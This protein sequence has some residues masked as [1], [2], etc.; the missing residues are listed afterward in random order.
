MF[1]IAI[2]QNKFSRNPCM[3]WKNSSHQILNSM[4]VC[5]PPIKNGLWKQFTSVQ[6]L[7]GWKIGGLL[8]TAQ[9]FRQFLSV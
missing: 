4:G 6:A 1:R 8:I 7:N 2:Q 5:L 9:K 3:Q